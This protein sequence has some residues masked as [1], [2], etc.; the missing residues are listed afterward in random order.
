M[1]GEHTTS[2]LRIEKL[3]RS[4]RRALTS[5]PVTGTS[6]A[7]PVLYRQLLDRG[8]QEQKNL[9][10]ILERA[11]KL[12]QRVDLPVT[13]GLMGR[14]SSGKSSLLNCILARLLGGDLPEKHRRKTANTAVDV[15]FTY[16]THPDYAERFQM[17][18][19]L[20]LDT[21]SHAALREISLIDTPGTGW[22]DFTESEVVELLSCCDCVLFLSRPTGLL[23]SESVRAL[24]IKLRHFPDIPL[25]FVVTDAN[26][27]RDRKRADWEQLDWKQFETDLSEAQAA[28]AAKAAVSEE[29]ALRIHNV[30][31]GLRLTR[32]NTFLVDARDPSDDFG[33]EALLKFLRSRYGSPTA[34]AEKA[35]AVGQELVN[36]EQASIDLFEG[37]GRGLKELHRHMK[38]DL[39]N[40]TNERLILAKANLR[41]EYTLTEQ[42]LLTLASSRVRNQSSD[43]M[44][45]RMGNPD[46]ARIADLDALERRLSEMAEEKHSKAFPLDRQDFLVDFG[47]LQSSALVHI[48]K[49]LGDEVRRRTAR[50][51][52]PAL[53]KA[54]SDTNSVDKDSLLRLERSALQDQINDRGRLIES[55]FVKYT[56]SLG[57]LFGASDIAKTVFRQQ[58]KWLEASKLDFPAFCNQAL[59]KVDNTRT[60]GVAY[61]QHTFEEMETAAER[62]LD[63]LTGWIAEYVGNGVFRPQLETLWWLSNED[64]RGWGEPV[65]L[66]TRRDGAFKTAAELA[67]RFN[68]T[69]LKQQQDT[70]TR[71][72]HEKTSWEQHWAFIEQSFHAIIGQ[73]RTL[74]KWLD[75]KRQHVA[76]TIQDTKDRILAG[77]DDVLAQLSKTLQLTEEEVAKINRE[78]TQDKKGAQKY[79]KPMEILGAAASLLFSLYKVWTGTRTTGETVVFGLAFLVTIVLISR[80]LTDRATRD[81]QRERARRDEMQTFQ[82][83]RENS[84]A[85][86]IN[87]LGRRISAETQGCRQLASSAYDDILSNSSR[88]RN[89]VDQQLSIALQEAAKKNVEYHQKVFT[90]LAAN[91]STAFEEANR[92]LRQI[93]QGLRDESERNGMAIIDAMNAKFAAFVE[94]YL[95][96]LLQH[97]DAVIAIANDLR[98]G[99]ER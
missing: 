50:T 30:L 14:F 61:V 4:G 82:R 48:S 92:C 76:R 21:V 78:Q 1:P 13:I 96:P 88:E 99:R 31:Q 20:A 69:I 34:L 65:D 22:L 26:H 7:I 95:R 3:L 46:L 44:P 81:V 37:V 52:T 47:T 38:R 72:S 19:R 27:Y 79:K 23:D 64:V 6:T 91:E 60:E 17:S 74:T 39:I 75:E 54:A 89:S 2:L 70:I 43:L 93:A 66:M 41:N 12:R 35:H 25:H 55:V 63:E 57:D 10:T 98:A 42:R 11:V 59:V 36:L 45:S 28:L 87:D 71:L 56:T 67:K 77:A 62:R 40:A 80:I 49:F 8:Q 33:V 5:L 94:G 16:I 9:D 51:R 73:A 32:D 24:D 18:E 83:L 68:D 15:K 29:D 53:G 85:A 97:A 86:L 58:M 84:C 90:L